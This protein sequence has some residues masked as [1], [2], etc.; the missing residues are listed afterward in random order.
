[1][2]LAEQT[3]SVVLEEGELDGNV[4]NCLDLLHDLCLDK[5]VAAN[6]GAKENY[7]GILFPGDAKA[8]CVHD[9]VVK[10]RAPDG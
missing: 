10:V 5:L 1:M 4:P 9:R 7:S 2:T 3:L 6:G 8:K